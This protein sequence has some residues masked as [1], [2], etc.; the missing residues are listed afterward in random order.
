MAV[1]NYSAGLFSNNPP[2]PVDAAGRDEFYSGDLGDL[3]FRIDA[4]HRVSAFSLSTQA[5]RGIMFKKLDGERTPT[6]S[7]QVPKAISSDGE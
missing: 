6:S 3:V 5:S 1:K 4:G 2:I 7:I